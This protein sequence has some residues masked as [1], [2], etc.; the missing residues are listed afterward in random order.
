M[1]ETEI[2]SPPFTTNMCTPVSAYRQLLA[3]EAWVDSL[4]PWANEGLRHQTRLLSP[5]FLLPQLTLPSC[6]TCRSRVYF[7]LG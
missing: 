5:S 7:G 6:P 2:T 4:R 3:L 1:N